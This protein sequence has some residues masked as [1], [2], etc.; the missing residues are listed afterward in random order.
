MPYIYKEILED[1]EIEA[2]VVGRDIAD[3]I[4]EERDNAITERD[5]AISERDKAFETI[6]SLNVELDNAK[7]KFAETILNPQ[8]SVRPEKSLRKNAENIAVSY[9]SLFGME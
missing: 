5:N 2:D 7:K 3:S 8:Q 9:K 6:K 1:S 4:A